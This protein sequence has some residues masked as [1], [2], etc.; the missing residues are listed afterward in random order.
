MK[1]ITFLLLF[2]FTAAITGFSQ[3]CANPVSP[4]IFQANFN[5]VAVQQTN[6]KKLEKANAFVNANCLM[7]AQVKNIA[8][9]FSED[10][11]RL[12]FCKNA[13]W[14]TF[15]RVNFYDVYD[16]FA[17]FSFAFRL[18]DYIHAPKPAAPEPAILIS[19]T[20]IAAGPVYPNVAYPSSA[21]Y[22]S[23]KG[24]NGP[25]LNEAG[26]KVIAQNVFTQP[27][28]ESKQVA[29][30]NASNA[31]CLDFAQL[32]KL[33]S[34]MRSETFRLQVMQF[35]YPRIYDLE[36][37][38]SGIVL[39]TTTQMQN[40]WIAYASGY[41]TPPPPPPAPVVICTT[42]TADFSGIMSSIKGKSFP[43]DKMALVEI[44]ARDRC[45]SVDQVRMI[46]KE[47]SSGDDKVKVYKM[48]Y[49]KCPDQNN[50]YKVVDDLAFS[51]DKENMNNFL[52]N[53]GK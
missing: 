37:Y 43:A 6:Q 21:N 12:E 30:Q 44:L 27:T 50:Y 25:V 11:Y 39:F 52:K 18:H 48:L 36:N 14:H 32:M 8:Q 24:C 41:L 47:F 35:A 7:A 22:V 28:D 53:G 5:Q 10:S 51:S 45:F 2:L 1:K 23:R 4:Q 9:L 13:Y 29:I 3:D 42:A 46:G 20:P 19:P 33:A 40:E 38:Q 49:A 17:A 31:N 15:D 34:L 26:F 16:A